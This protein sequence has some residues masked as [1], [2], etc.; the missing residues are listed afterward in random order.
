VR[1][2]AVIAGSEG[3]G[4]RLQLGEG[5]GLAGLGGQP[6][7]QGLPEPLHLALGLGVV[8][9][10]VLL[11]HAEAAQLGFQAVAAA[12]A[13]GEP[14]GEDHAVECR[15]AWRPGRFRHPGRLRPGCPLYLVRHAADPAGLSTCPGV[16]DVLRHPSSMS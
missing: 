15:S 9:L 2:L 1:A 4:Q 10:A 16:L 7:L 3:A 8:R 13:A 5:G 14:G 11:L 12:L 6:L